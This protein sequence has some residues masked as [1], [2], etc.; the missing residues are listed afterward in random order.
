M[1]SAGRSTEM[2]KISSLCA[3]EGLMKRKNCV[4]WKFL[5]AWIRN[6]SQKMKLNLNIAR[7]DERE[8]RKTGKWKIFSFNGKAQKKKFLGKLTSFSISLANLTPQQVLLVECSVSHCELRPVDKMVSVVLGLYDSEESAMVGEK[9]NGSRKKRKNSFS[10]FF[11]G[12]MCQSQVVV[13]AKK[14]CKWVNF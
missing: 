1:W 13:S 7:L 4:D 11:H 10:Q 2:G 8:M 5:H 14:V 6:I 12:F 3:G 9:L